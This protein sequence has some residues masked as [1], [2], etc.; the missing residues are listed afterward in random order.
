MAKLK[1]IHKQA[2]K[3][4]AHPSMK[5][6]KDIPIVRRRSLI[7]PTRAPSTRRKLISQPVD[8]KDETRFHPWKWF[9]YLITFW[10][11]P[12]ALRLCGKRDKATQQG[13]R[14]KI[15][16]CFI[17]LILCA[18]VAF[19]TFGLQRTLCPPSE[20]SESRKR[21]SSFVNNPGPFVSVFGN[22]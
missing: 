21:V 8:K 20:S 5:S 15:A 1:D 19:L 17:I 11:P 2:A 22:V 10:A 18:A 16:L 9:S 13:F 3:I 6:A 14:E 12:F 7:D 4:L